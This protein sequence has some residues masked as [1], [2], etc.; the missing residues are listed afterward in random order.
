M[1]QDNSN[2]NN[3]NMGSSANSNQNMNMIIPGRS[4]QTK[5][6][7]KDAIK[8]TLKTFTGLA[9]GFG[10]LNHV[11]SLQ[12]NQTL[13]L[14]SILCSALGKADTENLKVQE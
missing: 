2:N 13:T 1:T 9:F 14:T 6:I 12:S 10:A 7:S 4:L 5:I 11:G 3:L 8:T